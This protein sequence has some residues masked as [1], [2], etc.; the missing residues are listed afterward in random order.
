MRKTLTIG[1]PTYKRCDAVVQRLNEIFQKPLP[2]RVSVLVIDNC[3]D[4]GTYEKV[5]QFAQNHIG[6]HVMRNAQNLG[7]A[8][9]LFRLIEEAESD[10]LMIDSDEDE[11]LVQEL[12]EYIDFLETNVPCFVSPQ[13]SVFDRIYR[14][15]GKKGDIKPEQF[16]EA[17]NYI[18]GITFE[19]PS[20]RIGIERVSQKVSIN[21]AVFV[22]PQVMLVAEVLAKSKCLWYPEILTVKRQQLSSHIKNLDGSTYSSLAA[23]LQ[24]TTGFVEYLSERAAVERSETGSNV[25]Q[26]MLAVTGQWTFQHMRSGLASEHPMLLSGFDESAKNFYGGCGGVCRLLNKVL[27]VFRQPGLFVPWIKR[28]FFSKQ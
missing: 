12:P 1:I 6:L 3:S 7:F 25:F 28:K 24:Q 11:L 5:L 22:Y 2:D 20:A 13:A 17:S 18:S 23:R 21:A 26:R 16:R 10:Y 9:N 15:L 4:D 8:G 19:V 27:R 14:G